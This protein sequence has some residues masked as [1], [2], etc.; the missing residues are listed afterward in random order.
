MIVTCDL[1]RFSRLP[2]TAEAEAAEE[3]VSTSSATFSAA[4]CSTCTTCDGLLPLVREAGPFTKVLRIQA[5]RAGFFGVSVEIGP[6]LDR[7]W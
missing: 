6:F 3:A 4:A 2:G 7:L 5:Q 1:L